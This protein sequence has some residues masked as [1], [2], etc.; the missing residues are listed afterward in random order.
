[1][2]IV[3]LAPGMHGANRTGR[4][5]TGDY[6]GLV[7]YPALQ[8]HG[9]CRGRFDPD[10]EDDLELIDCRI[11]NAVRCL[12][13]QNK[14]IGAEINA[15]R[16]FLSDELTAAV[17]PNVVLTLGRIAFESTLRALGQ[18][19]SR[20]SFRHAGRSTLADGPTI[21]TSYHTSRYNINTG[22]L[23]EAMFDEVLGSIRRLVGQRAV[24]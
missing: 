11:T 20:F 1:M 14:P 12:P 3:G 4:P 13:P 8:R 19:P 22:R 17:A 16:S 5:F 21:V 7:L 18:R 9:W 23:T 6:A 15:C 2:L 10:G 24:R